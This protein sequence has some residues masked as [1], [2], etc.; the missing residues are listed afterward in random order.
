M[1]A[2]SP[3]GNAIEL[4]FEG[5]VQDSEEYGSGRDQMVSRVFF[6]IK[7][8]GAPPGDF[9][10]DLEL[11]AGGRFARLRIEPAEGYTGPM[12]YADLRQTV[13]ED[14]ET[15]R[16]AVG[17]PVGYSGPF[18]QEEFARLATTYF[19]GVASDTGAMLRQE[20]G[21][22]LRGSLRETAHVRLRH[23]VEASR[24]TVR[25]EADPAEGRA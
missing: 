1:P 13:G 8:V 25:F 12:L 14:F 15:G 22:P 23:N 24:S 19:R 2:P 11:V 9:R 4:T 7:R 5:C 10:R 20:E 16:V 6:W 21:R 18:N 17:P 3:S